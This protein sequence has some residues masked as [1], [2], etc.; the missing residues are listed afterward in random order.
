LTVL[1]QLTLRDC[2]DLGEIATGVFSCL[3]IVSA[4]FVRQQL[5]Q[6]RRDSEIGLF[7]GMTEQMLE[8]DRLLVEHPEMRKY[9]GHSAHPANDA[10]EESERAH[11]IAFAFANA[12]DHVVTHYPLMDDDARAAWDDYIENL[13]RTSPALAQTLAS[14]RAWWPRLQRKIDDSYVAAAA[15]AQAAAKAPA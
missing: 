8:I 13:H 7:T 15:G 12:L 10:S 4:W 5:K 3:A 6:S 1:A 2:A 11:A 14:H 9:F